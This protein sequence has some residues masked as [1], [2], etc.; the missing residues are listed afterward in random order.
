MASNGTKPRIPVDWSGAACMNIID[1]SA[2]PVLNIPYSVPQED[3]DQ[4]DD[5]VADS[6]T[7]QFFA[8]CRARDPQTFLPRWITQAD[9][10]AAEAVG[11]AAPDIDPEDVFETSTTWADC[12]N[13]ITP[14]D[15][16]RPI[17]FAAAMEGQDWDT[18]TLPAGTYT[19]EGY[20]WE[21]ALN[22]YSLHP[23]VYKIVD[24]P[25]LEAS[26]PALAVTNTEEVINRDETVTIAGCVSAME[27]S[28]ITAYWGRA[29]QQ[30]QWQPFVQDDPVSGDMF[31][32]EFTPPEELAGES[33]MVRVDVTDPMGRTY[34]NYMRELVIVLGTDGPSDCGGGGF[35]GGAGCMDSS[36]S[37]GSDGSDTGDATGATGS[38]TTPGQTGEDGGGPGGCGCRS[39]GSGPG[40]LGLF[41]LML[42]WARRRSA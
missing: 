36:G 16:R 12:W 2:S 40:G 15:Q 19:I 37:A 28:T 39:Q 3:L 34:T 6:R 33:A 13:R 38:A 10:A 25:E 1:R 17:S 11:A 21:P 7:H 4:T 8:M 27:G 32:V 35:I 20:T 26:G 18:S 41:A 31:A 30:V 42:L 9:I 22:I 23:G 24:S 29:E 14:D 5:E